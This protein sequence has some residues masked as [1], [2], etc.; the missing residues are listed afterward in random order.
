[1]SFAFPSLSSARLTLKSHVSERASLIMKEPEGL[2][3]HKWLC[4]GGFYA[5]CWDW[6][7]VFCGVGLLPFGG[8]AYLA[9]S[10]KCFFTL[11]DSE[12]GAVPG[13]ITP[14]GASATLAH[15]K[16]VL[17]W[18][19]FLAAEAE[20]DFDQFYSF[21]GKMRA[22][23]FF[24]RRERCVN[25]VYVWHDTMECGADDLP[26]A[27][28]PSR[29]TAAWTDADLRRTSMPDIHT[30][31]VLERRAMAGFC[32][33]WATGAGAAHAEALLEE[34]LEHEAAA[35]EIAKAL[36]VKLWWWD[37]SHTTGNAAVPRRGYY[38]GYDAVDGVRLVNRTYQA[39]WPLWAGLAAGVEEREAALVE[40]LQPDLR[41]SFG[42]RSTSSSDPRFTLGDFIVPYSNWRGPVWINVNTV[43]A[44]T[45]ASCGRK[46]EALKLASELTLM[47]AG[48]ITKNNAM[49][50]C[51]H[52]DD[53]SPLSSESKGFLSW[54]VLVASL[55]DNL[56]ADRDPFAAVTRWSS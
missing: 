50:E 55:L 49:H 36:N 22:L 14:N 23:L 7:A 17:I 56:E 2:L 53:G 29:H 37:D 40:L 32:R 6:D 45:L 54:N 33:A 38:V 13:C 16:P 51:Y 24:W 11:T 18:G 4:P 10:M 34:A 9:G 27:A 35:V 48:D 5:Q 3:V 21:A 46:D 39:A 1:M 26:F 43:L 30:F 52:P 41:A 31:L 42:I 12:S 25:D 19:A 8:S 28:V 47:L 15:A 44:Y 20:G